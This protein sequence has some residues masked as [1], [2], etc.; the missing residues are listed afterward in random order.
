MTNLKENDTVYEIKFEIT[1]S[2]LGG[3]MFGFDVEHNHI[4]EYEGTCVY[5]TKNEAIESAI[6]HLESLKDVF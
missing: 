1:T 5:Q 2:T 4:D 3:S 6:K